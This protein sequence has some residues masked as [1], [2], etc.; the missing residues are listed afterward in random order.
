[1]TGGMSHAMGDQGSR[2]CE[3]G[4][5]EA[6]RD[7]D[8]MAPEGEER[9]HDETPAAREKRGITHRSPLPAAEYD[10]LK[11]DARRGGSRSRGVPAQRDREQQDSGN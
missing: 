2:A 6:G 10:R 11:D 3:E 9:G 5:A 4:T 1:M 8:P 7:F